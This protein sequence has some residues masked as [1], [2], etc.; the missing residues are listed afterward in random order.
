MTGKSKEYSDA[1][2]AAYTPAKAAYDTAHPAAPAFDPTGS[3]KP[4]DSNTVSDI[5]AWLDAHS[6]DHTGKTLKADLLALVP[7]A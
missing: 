7:T 2:T 4:T 5:T 3:V 1:Y 6:I